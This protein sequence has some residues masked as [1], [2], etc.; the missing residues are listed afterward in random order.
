MLVPLNRLYPQLIN[1]NCY[2]TFILGDFHL[3]EDTV[4]VVPE[5]TKVRNIGCTVFEYGAGIPLREAVDTVIATQGGWKVT[6]QEDNVEEEYSPAMVDQVNINTN[7]FFRPILDL[8]PH[9]S[10]GL[11]W[12]P[13]HG[14]AWRFSS[15]EMLL[16][17]LYEVFYS[18][19]GPESIDEQ[20]GDLQ[21]ELLEHYQVLSETYLDVSLLNEVSHEILRDRLNLMFQWI[22][23]MEQQKAA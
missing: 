18:E 19:G 13:R 6:M 12:E 2:D 20:L 5:G 9:L 1:L 17:G 4:L 11:R 21:E 22:Q 23:K 10:L 14:E 16:M 15:V 3:D 7:A 8:L